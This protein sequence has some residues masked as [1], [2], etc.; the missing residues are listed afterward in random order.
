L[1]LAV[2]NTLLA[3]INSILSSIST[4]NSV[5]SLHLIRRNR[6]MGN[7]IRTIATE[8][9][10][11]GDT[12]RIQ[13]VFTQQETTAFGDMTR[14]YNPVHYVPGWASAKGFEGLICHGL[15]VGS[16]VCEFGGQVG[17]LA[18][19]M[20][21]KY[22]KPVYFGDTVQ[23]TITITRIDDMGRAEAEAWFTNQDDV[24]VCLAQL[25]GRIPVQAERKRLSGMLEEGDPT[26]PLGDARY[27]IERGP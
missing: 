17:W 19:G 4:L 3:F 6:S 20:T 13:R 24:Q 14:D 8:G 7:P 1:F 12:F 9:L 23:C 18:T 11:V 27:A 22:L 2:R 25:T 26:N 10:R 16:M 5:I 15:L 21:F